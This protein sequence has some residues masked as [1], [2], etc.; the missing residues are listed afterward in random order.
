MADI[1]GIASTSTDPDDL[2][3]WATRIGGR[4]MGTDHAEEFGRRNG[5]PGELLVRVNPT[6]VV[7]KT[8]VAD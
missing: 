8:G 1:D 6:R 3:T 4:Y 7:A 5:V 2:L